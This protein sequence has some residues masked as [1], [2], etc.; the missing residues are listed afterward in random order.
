MSKRGAKDNFKLSIGIFVGI[1]AGAHPSCKHSLH[2]VIQ[3]ILVVS[4][5]AFPAASST[6]YP[7]QR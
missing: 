6:S 5:L 7:F 2:H 1:A 4:D 3:V